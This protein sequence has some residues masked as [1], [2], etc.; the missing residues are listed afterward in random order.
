[1]AAGILPACLGLL[2]VTDCLSLLLVHFPA[3]NS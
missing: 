3:D 2:F 1:M